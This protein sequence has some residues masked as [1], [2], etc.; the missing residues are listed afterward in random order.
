[1]PLA[2]AAT[3]GEIREGDFSDAI[4]GC[5]QPPRGTNIRSEKSCIDK[6]FHSYIP[7]KVDTGTDTKGPSP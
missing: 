2:R 5:L 1:M 7:V 3:R 6:I 4:T